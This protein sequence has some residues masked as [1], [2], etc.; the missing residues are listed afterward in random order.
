MKIILSFILYGFIIGFFTLADTY[1]YASNPSP[2]QT[3]SYISDEQQSDI[4]DVFDNS[5]CNS[6]IAPEIITNVHSAL[7]K[8]NQSNKNKL[9]NIFSPEYFNSSKSIKSLVFLFDNISDR[10][11]YTKYNTIVILRHLII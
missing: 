2:Y 1:V 7:S 11:F 4:E 5:K 10:L 9:Q 3:F 8:N 6:Y